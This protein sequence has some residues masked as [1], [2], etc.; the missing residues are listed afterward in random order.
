MSWLAPRTAR[1]VVGGARSRVRPLEDSV[2]QGTVWGPPLW[3]CYY[4]DCSAAVALR[5]FLD[6]IF[7]DDLNCTKVM[8]PTTSND[9]AM[10]AAK[11]CQA[12][13]HA[14]GKGNRVIFDQDKESFHV[15]HRTR[16]HGENFTILG[17][18]FDVGLRMHD[19]A[20]K[21]STEAGWRLKTLLRTRRHHTVKEMV[22]LYKSQVMAYVES[23][24]VGLHHACPTTLLCVDRVQRRFLREIGITEQQALADWNLAPLPSRRAIAM[25]GLL[26]RV[27]LRKAPAPLCA[28][29]SFQEQVRPGHTTTRGFV[30]RHRFQLRE[31]AALGGHTEVFRRSF[32]GLA[33][34]W[35][36][37][38]EEV[39]LSGSVSGFQKLLQN[40][41]RRR[42]SE[43]CD[44]SNFFSEAMRMTVQTFQGTFGIRH[45]FHARLAS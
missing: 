21:V 13:V 39:V 45:F 44:F 20:H 25:L 4:A 34:V 32:F 17:T 3:N 42:A 11:E 15:L 43:T 9:E 41:L 26:Y 23:R 14:W 22:T 30:R 19:A 18:E 31:A 24:T 1:V 36:M 2:F 7:A 40:A 6:I 10:A 27:A 5:G 16:G 37:V 35:N 8:D 29:F 12:E 28:L 33:T 38:P